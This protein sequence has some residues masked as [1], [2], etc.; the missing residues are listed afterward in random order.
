M[1]VSRAIQVVRRAEQDLRELMREA[2]DHQQYRQLAAIAPIADAI[3]D[4]VRR[5]ESTAEPSAA[6]TSKLAASAPVS[7]RTVRPQAKT[8]ARDEY[9]RFERDGDKLVK[10][11]WSKKDKREYEHRAP[12]NA[13]FCVAE[14]LATDI[15]PSSV[16]SMDTLMPF[17][18]ADG[19]DI[20]SYQ[21]YLALAWFR[22]LSAVDQ[23]GKEGYSV[24]DGLLSPKHVD[25]AWNALKSR[26]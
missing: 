11:A 23:R 25:E 14:R 22:T 4:I 12:R 10:I 1:E 17:K 19:N 26:K 24:T 7:T 18:D 20:P 9:P 13:V 2:L 15:K 5:A 6:T 16:F 8:T 21:A 3:S